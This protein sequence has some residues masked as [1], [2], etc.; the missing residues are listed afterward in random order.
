MADA[1]ALA[2]GLAVLLVVEVGLAVVFAVEEAEAFAVT[3]AV[4]FVVTFSVGVGDG[5]LVAAYALPLN[6][7][8]AS[9]ATKS[10]LNLDPI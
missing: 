8:T 9:T 10:F 2:D 4:A 1:V 7:E 6:N 5:F 3:L